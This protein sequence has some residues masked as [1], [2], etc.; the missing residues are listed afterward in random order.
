MSAG[1]PVPIPTPPPTPTLARLEAE[2]EELQFPSF[3]FGD[4]WA[5][6]SSLVETGLR[7]S[8]PIAI[9]ITVNGQ[10]LFHAGLPG[11]NPDNDQWL[12]RKA[13]VVMRFHRSSLLVAQR[14]KEEGDT[15]EGKFGLS[16]ADYAPYGGAVALRIRSVGVVGTVSVSGLADHEDHRLAA[17]AMRRRLAERA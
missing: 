2:H 7:D 10:V 15:L 5:I 13:R 3:G 9:D 16:P 17:D 12:A 1:A 11:T 14:L 6:G 8:L 4:A